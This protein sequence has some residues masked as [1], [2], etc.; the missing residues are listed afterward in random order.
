MTTN[1]ELEPKVYARVV[2][3]VDDWQVGSYTIGKE[4]EAF[5]DTDWADFIIIDDDG[6]EVGCLWH[7]DADCLFERVIR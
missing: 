6:D 2:S 3:F 5:P 7:G 4:Y 1:Q